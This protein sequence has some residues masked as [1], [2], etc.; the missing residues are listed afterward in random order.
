M[1]DY[2][3]VAIKK[4]VDD[5]KKV[6]YIRNIITQCLYLLYLVYAVYENM[7]GRASVGI[8]WVNIALLTLSLAYFIFFMVMTRGQPLLPP[9]KTQK[10]VAL[11]FKRSKQLLKLFTLGVMVYGI[12]ATTKA[13]TPIGVVLSALMIVGWVLQIIF[14]VLIRIFINRAQFIIEGLEA[15]YENLVKPAKAVGNFFKKITGKEVEP[16]KEKSKTRLWL[17]R[18]VEETRI[19]KSEEKKQKK[20]EY[21]RKKADKKQAK[22]QARK[23]AKDTVFISP[24]AQMPALE[25][26]LAIEVFEQP[27]LLTGDVSESPKK[28]KRKRKNKD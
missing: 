21:K 4:T 26:N 23:D 14:E 24:E 3:K 2:T 6:D 13:L 9:R 5:F 20:L 19:E 25:E 11:L 16:Q 28:K 8:F 15:D 1:L 17:D 18:R 7:S 12:Y 27:P 22:K 10:F